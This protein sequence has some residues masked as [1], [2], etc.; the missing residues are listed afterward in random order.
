VD[1]K[2][3][4]F[5]DPFDVANLVVGN[6]ELTINMARRNLVIAPAHDVRVEPD[7]YRVSTSKS[8]PE[9]LQ[10]GEIVN[11]DMHTQ[12]FSFFELV[13]VNTLGGEQNPVGRKTPPSVPT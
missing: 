13:E 10:H 11:I 5:D 3:S 2:F 6:A 1:N 7:A 8:R 12:P 9:L 4:C